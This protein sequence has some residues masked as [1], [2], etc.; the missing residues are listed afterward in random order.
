MNKGSYVVVYT[1]C[2]TLRY[3]IHDRLLRIETYKRVLAPGVSRDETSYCKADC[4]ITVTDFSSVTNNPLS[5]I[6]RMN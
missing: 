5:Q 6:A 1:H 4:S 2:E 3:V